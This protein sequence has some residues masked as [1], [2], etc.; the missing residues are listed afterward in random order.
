[1]GLVNDFSSLSNFSYNPI[2]D[3]LN[4]L[5]KQITKLIKYKEQLQLAQS[6]QK[7][8]NQD[9]AAFEITKLEKIPEPV[10][11]KTKYICEQAIDD[12]AKDLN[13]KFASQDK[14]NKIKALQNLK[15]TIEKLQKGISC[16]LETLKET[17]E[18]SLID[19]DLCKSTIL[20]AADDQGNLSISTLQI[21]VEAK[22]RLLAKEIEDNSS[23]K[24][25]I[26]TSFK[27]NMNLDES[28]IYDQNDKAQHVD[29]LIESSLIMDKSLE[30][31]VCDLITRFQKL[32]N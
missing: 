17:L 27:R 22:E 9:L 7:S 4:E 13:K 32:I 14:E 31:R 8:V 19:E 12:R 6:S 29:S 24:K 1:M 18:D 28:V 20:N 23:Q 16:S 25:S 11:P 3:Q 10:K 21:E 2:I 5:D 15:S 26:T 30:L